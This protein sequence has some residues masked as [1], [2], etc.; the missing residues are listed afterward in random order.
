MEETVAF[1]DEQYELR[2]F[3]VQERFR[4]WSQKQFKRR[5]TVPEL[6]ARIRQDAAKC[7]FDESKDPQDEAMRTRFICFI[8]NEA[9]L[10]VIFKLSEEE[11]KFSK[12]VKIFQDT[13]DA[14]EAVNEQCYG[15][16][17]EPVLKVKGFQ[18]LQEKQRTQE[19]QHYWKH[20]QM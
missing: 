4:F 3:I 20:L 12:A 14:A 6:A 13:E 8:G 7:G 10:K 1:M 17:Q 2:K 11:L 5:E 19:A 15:S 16:G 18:E 9:V